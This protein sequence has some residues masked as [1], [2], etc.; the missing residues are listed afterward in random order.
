MKI[1]V[2]T[3]LGLASQPIQVACLALYHE[4]AEITKTPS[5]VIGIWI[6]STKRCIGPP[7][8][9][10]LRSIQSGSVG[11]IQLVCLF[12]P[13]FEARWNSIL[14]ILK[15]H[16]TFLKNIFQN[17]VIEN[18]FSNVISQIESC[19]LKSNVYLNIEI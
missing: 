3:V 2:Q 5:E 18:T 8:V 17:M 13:M 16:T 11:L 7:N 15:K 9:I 6:G 12:N 4:L 10:A 1:F 19:L 14:G